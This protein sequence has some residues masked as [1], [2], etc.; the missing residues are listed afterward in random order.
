MA[1]TVLLILIVGPMLT[2]DYAFQEPGST[3][4]IAS[5]HIHPG[6]SNASGYQFTVTGS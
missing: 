2:G 3:T 1:Q 6:F 5:A 4:A